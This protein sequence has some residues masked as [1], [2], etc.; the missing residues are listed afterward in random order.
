MKRKDIILGLLIALAIAVFLSPFASSWPDGLERIAH[1]LGFI[2][3]S[4]WAPAVKAPMPDYAFPGMENEML[5]TALSGLIGTVAM[6]GIGYGLACLLRKRK[7]A[8]E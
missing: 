1:N 5:A 6:F 2:D 4:D 8:P 7:G 3:R